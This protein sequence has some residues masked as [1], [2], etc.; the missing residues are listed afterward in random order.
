[1]NGLESSRDDSV[2]VIGATNRPLDLDGAVVRRLPHRLLVRIS[3]AKR[4]E[5]VRN[6]LGE[7]RR[8]IVFNFAMNL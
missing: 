4:K 8:N 2:I 5:K 3:P 6:L 7:S 1:M